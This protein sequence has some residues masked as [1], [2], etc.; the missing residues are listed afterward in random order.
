MAD[1]SPGGW[2]AWGMLAA[3]LV[4]LNASLVFENVWPTPRI[5]W[6]EALSLELACLVPCSPRGAGRPPS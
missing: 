6:G 3:S 1:R 5:R 2:R 4:L